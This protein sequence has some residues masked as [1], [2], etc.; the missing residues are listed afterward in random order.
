MAKSEAEER[1]QAVKKKWEALRGRLKKEYPTIYEETKKFFNII[2]DSWVK[3]SPFVGEEEAYG[4]SGIRI[5]SDQKIKFQA[6]DMI[7]WVE[8]F[9]K[10]FDK[11]DQELKWFRKNR[12]TLEM[13]VKEYLEA[14]RLR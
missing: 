3:M 6:I 1:K 5:A 11:V 4:E 12:E 14:E 8:F 7:F 13:M 2:E 9:K 10:I